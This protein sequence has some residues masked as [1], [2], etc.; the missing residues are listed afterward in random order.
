[1]MKKACYVTS[2]LCLAGAAANLFRAFV[3][4]R[5]FMNGVVAV[6]CCFCSFIVFFVGLT[7]DEE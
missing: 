5:A 4:Q 1:M 6:L 2:F 7:L 3:G